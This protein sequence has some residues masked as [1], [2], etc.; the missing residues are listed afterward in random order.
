[1][2]G[3]DPTKHLLSLFNRI[4]SQLANGILSLDQETIGKV[5]IAL[6]AVNS[7]EHDIYSPIT[8][9]SVILK[10]LPDARPFFLLFFGLGLTHPSLDQRHLALINVVYCPAKLVQELT[11]LEKDRIYTTI[12]AKVTEA[13]APSRLISSTSGTYSEKVLQILDDIG[14]DLR[15]P[16]LL[17]HKFLHE[18]ED[19]ASLFSSD[20]IAENVLEDAERLIKALVYQYDHLVMSFPVL[21]RL[22]L[23]GWI[24]TQVNQ[25]LRHSMYTSSIIDSRAR[26]SYSNYLLSW[27]V[28]RRSANPSYKGT[29]SVINFKL[30][31]I[32]VGTKSQKATNNAE[33]VAE[34]SSGSEFDLFS[35]DNFG[36]DEQ[37]LTSNSKQSEAEAILHDDIQV[38]LSPIH[39]RIPENLKGDSTG[40]ARLLLDTLFEKV[41]FLLPSHERVQFSRFPQAFFLK[42]LEM[43]HTIDED[44]IRLLDMSPSYHNRPAQEV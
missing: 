19:C 27:T 20:N 42:Q 4:Y 36:E 33:I 18:Q 3:L 28:N 8:A 6:D 32:N 40:C 30:P 25:A 14:K 13:I 34:K 10:Y 15:E 5:L 12:F 24:S 41:H 22:N 21:G 1:M 26:Q 39:L 11:T 35:D 44:H 37:A 16:I 43:C 38:D 7:Y 9:L 2:E 31:Q 29:S 23:L 17:A